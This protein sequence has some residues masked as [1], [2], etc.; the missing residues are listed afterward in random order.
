MLRS[1]IKAPKGKLIK[2]AIDENINKMTL[3][4]ETEIPG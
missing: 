4:F 2:P 1:M 3:F